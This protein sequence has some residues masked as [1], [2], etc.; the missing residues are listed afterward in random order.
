MNTP[1]DLPHAERIVF[2][3]IDKAAKRGTP[4]PSNGVLGWAAGGK[5]DAMGGKLIKRLERRGLI[6]VSVFKMFRTVEIIATG[7]TTAQRP[8]LTDPERVAFRMIYDAALRDEPCPTNIDLEDAVGYN[9]SSGGAKL[10][11]KLE[12]HGHIRVNRFQRFRI[13]EITAIGKTTARHPS[14][15][16]DRPLVS[17][18]NGNA[19][20]PQAI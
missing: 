20:R 10:V 18:S 17:K 7:K 4:C 11:R 15:R 13:I 12:Q 14:M 5:S 2:D 9:T 1:D 8:F 3:M 19:N 6:R 16:V